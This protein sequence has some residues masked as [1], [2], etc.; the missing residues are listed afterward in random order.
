[1]KILIPMSGG[2][3]N[4]DATFSIQL[5]D[6]LVTFRQLY[7]TLAGKWALSASVDGVTIFS[8]IIL[9]VGGDMLAPF[10]IKETFG[11]LYLVGDDPSLDTLGVTNSLVWW[12]SDE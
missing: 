9:L 10:N 6:N 1:M 5:G 4:S 2:A 8:E 3:V 12:S 7:R 11:G